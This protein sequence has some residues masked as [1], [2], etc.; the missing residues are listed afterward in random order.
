MACSAAE[1]MLDWGALTTITPRSVA[2]ATSTLSSPIP[3]RPTTTRSVPAASTSAGDRGGRADDQGLGADHGRHQLLGGQPEL[4]I[5]LVA[6]LGHQVQTGLGQLLG[7]EHP[8][9]GVPFCCWTV[10]RG[11]AEARPGHD[12]SPNSLASRVTPSTRSSSPRAYDIRK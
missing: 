4:D 9:H 10:S 8:T 5:D 6:G 7:D 11:G 2:A 12:A 1:R 3:A